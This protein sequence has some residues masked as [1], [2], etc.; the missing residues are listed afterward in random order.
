MA[1]K[2]AKLVDQQDALGSF[3]DS[4]MRDVEANVE[5]EAESRQVSPD[6]TLLAAVPPMVN[7]SPLTPPRLVTIPRGGQNSSTAWKRRASL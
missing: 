7:A 1:T 4:L 3:F 2:S 5:Q 6:S